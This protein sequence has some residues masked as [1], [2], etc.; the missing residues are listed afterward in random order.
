M[1]YVYQKIVPIPE[2]VTVEVESN[3]IKVKGPK[4]ELTRRFDKVSCVIE[5]EEDNVVVS[6]YF[7]NKKK[8]GVTGTIAGHIKNMIYGVREGYVYHL[9]I[10]Y[11]HFPI[12]VSL[13]KKTR[14]LTIKGL[15]GYK[16]AIK[17]PIPEDVKIVFDGEDIRVSG[18]NI[19]IV[20][21]SAAR[22]QEACRL[23]GKRKKDDKK[24][25]DGIY[26]YKKD[27]RK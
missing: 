2:D 24:F 17:I 14:I 10:I 27:L 25:Q 20:S 26:I 13:D 21:Q 18:I 16:G 11:S 19:E 1:S 3:E 5:R 8:R 7:V 9:K 22:I 23:R 4:G 15:Y 6:D 12:E